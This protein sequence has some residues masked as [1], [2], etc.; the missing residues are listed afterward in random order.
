MLRKE[1][2]LAGFFRITAFAFVVLLIFSASFAGAA[3]ELSG[4]VGAPHVQSL[5]HPDSLK[6][7][8]N[9]TPGFY[10]NLPSD[11][12]GVSYLITDKAT[13]NPGPKSDG[14]I[15]STSFSQIPDGIQYFH[16]KFKEAGAWGPIAHFQFNVDTK[17][18][19]SF[20]AETINSSDSTPEISFEATDALSGIDHYEIQIGDGGVWASISPDQAG[21]PYRL[22]FEHAG[23]QNVS[24]KALDQAGNST[25]ASLSVVVASV[26]SSSSIGRWLSTAFNGI[27]DGISGYALLIIILAGFIGLLVLLFQVLGTAFD[28]AWHHMKD[29]KAI[30]KNERLADKTFE[31]LIKDMRDEIKF[32]NAIGKRRRLG[33]EEKYLKGKLEQYARAIKR[34]TE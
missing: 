33:P 19:E 3:F 12:T 30:R 34:G 14:V 27:V 1:G 4:G 18:P 7:Y 15:S 23:T 20:S 22:Q 16:V 8:S 6:W 25:L 32:L 10:W 11:V 24:L 21:K 31:H 28:K 29:K 9:S 17:G 2:Y 5:T 13:S 26:A